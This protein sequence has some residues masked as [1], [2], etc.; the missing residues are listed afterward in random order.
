M[1]DA[2][3]GGVCADAQRK[4][5]DGDQREPKILAHHADG[6]AHIARENLPVLARSGGEDPDDGFLPELRSIDETAALFDLALLLLEDTLH[7]SLIVGAE[8]EGQH[9]NESS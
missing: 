3:D 8:V 7:F 2:E 5:E 4:G 6:I 9:A 1:D